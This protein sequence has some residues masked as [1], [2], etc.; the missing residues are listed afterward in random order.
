MRRALP[1]VLGLAAAMATPRL[2]SSQAAAVHTV[3]A[4]DLPRYMGDWF[5]IARYPN[6]FQ[7]QCAGDV[8]VTY[9]LRDDGR[10]DVTNRCRRQTGELDVARGVARVIEG[11]GGARLKVRFA[12]GWLSWL[13]AVWGDYWVI[14]LDAGYQWAVVGHPDRDYLWILSRTTGLDDKA[15]A[16]A[17]AAARAQGYEL[18]RLQRTP[19]ASR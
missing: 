4:V 3:P 6:R 9:A 14:G 18:S 12:P 7:A 2:V 16:E 5:E 15:L 11:S 10:V 17:E 8:R 1:F 19:Q 13:P